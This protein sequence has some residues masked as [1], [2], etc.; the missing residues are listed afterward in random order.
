VTLNS[1]GS[2]AT[3]ISGTANVSST[4]SGL[5]LDAVCGLV[6]FLLTALYDCN[7][8]SIAIPITVFADHPILDTAVATS[9]SWFLRNKWHELTYYAVASTYTPTVGLP[10]TQP[11]CATGSTCLSVTNVTPAGGQRALLILAGRS[12]NG[13]ARPDSTLAN[14]LDQGNA[15]GAYVKL[16]VNSGNTHSTPQRFNDRIVV[17]DS[18]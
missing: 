14:Y 13:S 3:S 15:T 1:I 7:P 6:G 18:N 8:A 2:A 12:I 16:P 17:V 5:L 10:A 4:S 11:S 9:Y